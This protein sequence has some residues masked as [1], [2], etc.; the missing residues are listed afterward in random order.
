MKIMN[1]ELDALII[2][3]S[4]SSRQIYTCLS[5]SEDKLVYFVTCEFKI[6]LM[7]N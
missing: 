3:Y 2:K 6:N 5:F 4:A 7:I 1:D